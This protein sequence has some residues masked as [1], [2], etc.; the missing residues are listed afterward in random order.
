MQVK[1]FDEIEREIG[2]LEGVKFNFR[3]SKS[4]NLWNM[5]LGI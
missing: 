2:H 5:A 3:K 1:L 4:P